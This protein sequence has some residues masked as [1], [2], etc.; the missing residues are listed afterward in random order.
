MHKHCPATP[1]YQWMQQDACSLHAPCMLLTCSMR[2]ATPTLKV[3]NNNL[4]WEGT[5]SI[6]H[7]VIA[8]ACC[9]PG[10]EYT[11]NLPRFLHSASKPLSLLL[12]LQHE[13]IPST[14]TEN[15]LSPP[16]HGEW[17]GDLVM[18]LHQ[19]CRF[20]SDRCERNAQCN[21]P[22]PAVRRVTM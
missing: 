18:V 3:L 5:E 11:Q 22:M 17:C 9:H 20:H 6:L 19:G 10:S 4:C 2:Y 14:P 13:R 21:L 8:S 1:C 12:L 7:V 15:G 16:T